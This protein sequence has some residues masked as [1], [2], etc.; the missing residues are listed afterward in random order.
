RVEKTVNGVRTVYRVDPFS[1][2]DNVPQVLVEEAGGEAV[3][4]LYGLDLLGEVRAGTPTYYGYDALS[5]RL[6]LGEGGALTARYRYAP[7]G[8]VVGEGP[9]GYGFTGERWDGEVGLLYL[10]ARYYRPEIGGFIV[11]DP[12][13]GN[14][15][16]PQTLHSF[17]Y[18]WNNPVNHRDPAGLWVSIGEP[19]VFPFP[20][21]PSHPLPKKL[22]PPTAYTLISAFRDTNAW[23][24]EQVETVFW[25]CCRPPS[26]AL[27]RGAELVNLSRGFLRWGTWGDWTIE[28]LVPQPL[29]EDA[30]PYR[31]GWVRGI[32]PGIML[33]MMGIETRYG[34]RGNGMR[35]P[36]NVGPRRDGWPNWGFTEGLKR[37]M[38]VLNYW[39]GYDARLGR[40]TGASDNPRL[41]F[42]MYEGTLTF[43]EYGD[44]IARI[45]NEN[46]DLLASLQAG[47]RR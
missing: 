46:I 24:S 18:V 1:P 44:R 21:P 14:L 34:T 5:I 15:T 20:P 3:R 25:Y 16:K 35:N 32:N 9:A 39:A 28:R 6:G 2:V 12:S 22:N 40:Y 45:Y 8:E 47:E 13:G 10:R 17:L 29:C 43:E 33:A 31:P 41:A 23:T 27:G 36:W 30:F 7:F 19:P 26:P 38:L 37:A 42:E 11:R 4:Y